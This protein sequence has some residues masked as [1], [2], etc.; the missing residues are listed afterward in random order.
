MQ[1]Q[2]GKPIRAAGAVGGIERVH[3]KQIGLQ[4]SF[5]TLSASREMKIMI[6]IVSVSG[7]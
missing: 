1:A 4:E 7:C 6:L 2:T 3:L 5:S